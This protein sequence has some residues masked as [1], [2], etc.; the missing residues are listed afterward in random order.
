MTTPMKSLK[1]YRQLADR[2]KRLEAGFFTVEGEKSI[3]QI[4]ASKPDFIT[5]IVSVENPPDALR[6]YPTRIVSES[7][8]RYISSTQTPQGIMAVVKIPADLYSSNLPQDI[9]GRILLLEDIQ[10]PGNT[11]TLVRTAAAFGYD[12]V[13]LTEKGAE[14]LAPKCVQATSG[15]VL[16]LWLRRT[17]Q[18]LETARELKEKGY[19]IIAAE[20]K[21]KEKPEILPKQERLLLALGNEAAGLS[22]KLLEMADHHVGIPTT[23]EKAESLNVAA[24]GAI[25]M[26]LS[27]QK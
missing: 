18:Y 4:V 2:K 15:T 14:P 3:R 19:K 10:D 27:S 26:Y 20:V 22:P 23:P 16:S 6:D 5:E 21:G 24:C 17:D 1:W 9:G 11:G 7:Q 8:F 25:L 12:G 13:I